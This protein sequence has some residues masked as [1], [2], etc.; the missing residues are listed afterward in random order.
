MLDAINLTDGDFRL[1]RL[2][3][4]YVL[5]GPGDQV[6]R[7]ASSTID[8]AISTLNKCGDVARRT[9]RACLCCRQALSSERRHNRM[10]TGCRVRRSGLG[11]EWE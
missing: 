11:R 3:R 4:R 2:G 5:I 9:T 7:Q 6:V 8:V 10:C 1:E